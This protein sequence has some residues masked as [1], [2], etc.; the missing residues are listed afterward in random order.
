M[1]PERGK[2][3]WTLAEGSHRLQQPVGSHVFHPFLCRRPLN[4]PWVTPDS[5][6]GRSVSLCPP[7]DEEGAGDGGWARSAGAV[8]SPGSRGR[9]EPCADRGL[10]SRGRVGRGLL[11]ERRRLGR[12]AGTEGG[13]P[14]PHV[15]ARLSGVLVKGPRAVHCL[16]V[17]PMGDSDR[18]LEGCRDGELCATGG[19]SKRSRGAE[20]PFSWSHV[21]G[22]QPEH[23]RLREFPMPGHGPSQWRVTGSLSLG[24]PITHQKA[25]L[26]R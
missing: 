14:V 6:L 15:E 20:Q 21:W 13:L 8:R 10:C 2:D 12:G 24:K 3:N 23:G 16:C 11:E 7:P 19:S 4:P 9:W 26:Q 17:Q 25:F 18:G 22:G 5:C 1:D